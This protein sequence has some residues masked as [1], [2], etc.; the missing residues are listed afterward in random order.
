MYFISFNLSPADVEIYQ[1]A[2][3]GMIATKYDEIVIRPDSPFEEWPFDDISLAD[4]EKLT[5]KDNYPSEFYIT[6]GSMA[7][8]IYKF[9][10]NSFGSYGENVRQHGQEY[11]VFLRPLLPYE[12]PQ[13]NTWNILPDPDVD[14]PEFYMECFP[15]DGILPIP[16][17]QN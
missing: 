8:S 2:R 6:E 11:V 16:T 17:P 3:L 13:L 12:I 7:A 14:S 5:S 15:S 4:I 9:F 1:P 10:G